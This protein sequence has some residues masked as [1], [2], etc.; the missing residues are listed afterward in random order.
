M[1]NKLTIV[2]IINE[3]SEY[4]NLTLDSITNQTNQ[5]FNLYLLDKFNLTSFEDVKYIKDENLAIYSCESDYIYFMS[6]KDILRLDFVETL[7]WY[8]KY[9]PSQV[10]WFRKNTNFH[11]QKGYFNLPIKLSEKFIE[12]NGSD[13]KVYKVDFLL[14]NYIGLDLSKYR[15]NINHIMLNYHVFGNALEFYYISKQ[16]TSHL[17]LKLDDISEYYTIYKQMLEELKVKCYGFKHKKFITKCLI[18]ED[19]LNKKI[20]QK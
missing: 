3:L 13:D 9:K 15:Y 14:S 12:V 5:N 6:D 10:Y 4:F 19:F 1:K 17:P 20:L 11:L 2:L 7:Y 8:F 18:I 16:L